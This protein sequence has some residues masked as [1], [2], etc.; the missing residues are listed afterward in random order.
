MNYSVL[1]P[2]SVDF[3]Q[4][5]AVLYPRYPDEALAAAGPRPDPDALG[6]RRAERLRAPDDDQPAARHA[7]APGAA[8]RRLRRPPGD[9]LPGRRRG[10]DDRRPARTGRSSTPAA[11]RTSTSLW[12]VPAITSYPF[13]GSAIYYWDS[14]PIRDEPAGPGESS[15]P[16]RRRYENLPNRTGDD[17]HGAAAGDAGRAA[18]G[19]GLLRRRDPGKRQLRRGPCFAIGFSGP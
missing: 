19:L 12:S 3:D 4:F 18:A 5:A 11:G 15:A 8:E 14:G 1:L 13:T 16:N 17:P 10:A 2:R 7:A 6:P 9:R